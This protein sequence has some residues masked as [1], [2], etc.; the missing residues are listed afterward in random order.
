LC[1]G[2]AIWAALHVALVGAHH[3]MS[4]SGCRS[5]LGCEGVERIS[6]ALCEHVDV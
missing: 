5:E 4:R 1:C 6:H 3:R 2:N